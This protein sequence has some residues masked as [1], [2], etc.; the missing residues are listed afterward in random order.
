[1]SSTTD[2]STE[3]G[4]VLA[5]FAGGLVALFIIA[6][7]AF[8]VGV[9]YLE[10]RDQQNA[11]DAAALAGARYAVGA[12]N[13]S[14]TCAAA[15][16][17]PA[18]VA[19]C[20][21]ALA[22]DYDNADAAE[23][24]NVF[25]PAQ[26]GI[27]RHQPATVEVQIN[28]TRGSIF[29]GVI[30]RAVW[31]VGTFATAANQQELEYPFGMLALDPTGCKA[32]Q[33]SGTGTV[34]ANSNVQS[35]STGEGCGDGSN[36][37]FSRS[38]AGVLN[39]TAADAV[40][41]SAGAL[42]SVG[43]GTLNC[44][45][46]EYSFPLPDPLAGLPAPTHTAANTTPVLIPVGHTSAI[47]DY[48]PGTTSTGMKAFTDTKN[49]ACEV[50]KAW[51][52]GPGFYPGGISVK[53]NNAVAYLLPGIYW[54]GGGGFSTSNDGS[55]ITVAAGSTPTS[56]ASCQANRATCGAAGGV[57]IYNSTTT[58]SA[59]GKITLGGGGAV[60][61]LKPYLYPFGDPAVTTD[62]I[63]LVIFQDRTVAIGGDDVTLNGS[64]STA[65]EVRGIIYLP[66]GD[67]KV[68][69]SASVFTMDQVIAW[70]FL[71]NGSGGTVNVLRET[72]VNAIFNA[73]GLV[74]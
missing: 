26:H 4:Q 54:I 37:G 71:I 46:D 44:T 3:R 6:A 42:Q 70:N 56:L 40:C 47:P 48:C 36:I 43:S 30:G 66:Q 23:D 63:D 35:N 69:G 28:A 17:N 59:P 53:G 67:V 64:S 39:V 24:V 31:P 21:I 33:I 9:M 25:L 5:L 29:G 19:A 50:D 51:I 14:G 15:G 12:P 52:F 16:S 55:V 73:V 45:P 38:G 34:N 8:D 62:D 74:E 68:N 32:I 7:L 1:L 18:V 65:S 58:S 60:L 72:G 20:E 57:L 2:R 11:A 41:R 49:K 13:F 27:F 61:K 22:N 10:R